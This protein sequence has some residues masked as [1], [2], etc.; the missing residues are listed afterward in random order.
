MKTV[1]AWGSNDDCI[2]FG[3]IK[4]CDEFYSSASSNSNYAGKFAVISLSEGMSA[5]FIVPLGLFIHVIYDGCWSFAIS[6][7]IEEHMPDWKVT[8]TWG[9]DCEYSETLYIEVP[10]DAYLERIR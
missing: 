7:G 4:G 1:V 8:R 5:G 9:E 2:E 10:D 6:G 3:G